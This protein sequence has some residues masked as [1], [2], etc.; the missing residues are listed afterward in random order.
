MRAGQKYSDAIC[1]ICE[2]GFPD[3][4]L[5]NQKKTEAHINCLPI[6]GEGDFKIR[7]LISKIFFQTTPKVECKA[8]NLVINAVRESCEGKTIKKFVKKNGEDALWRLYM[9][10]GISEL[11]DYVSKRNVS[12]SKSIHLQ[13]YRSKAAL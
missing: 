5:Y 7:E 10:V 13:T 8:Y 1:V 3:T 6:L 11:A 12:I 9:G 4:S 2:E